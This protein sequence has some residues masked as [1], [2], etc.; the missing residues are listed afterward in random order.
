MN[1]PTR[2]PT[3]IPGFD[4]ASEHYYFVTICTYEKKCI[5]G[6]TGNLNLLG[7]IAERELQEVHGH[8]QGVYIDKMVIM[9]NHVH[10][11]IAIGCDNKDIVYPS[12]STIVGQYKSGVTRKIREIIPELTVWQRSYHDHII[13]N[14]VD[15]EKIWNYID[16]NPSK[17]MDDCYYIEY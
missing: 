1:I 15:Y 16:G 9:P 17:W 14:R 3:R 8:Y 13:R 4:Y 10:A 6:A 12:L 5:F 7:K 2:K 11:I